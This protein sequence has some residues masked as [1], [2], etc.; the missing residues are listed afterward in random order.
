MKVDFYSDEG[1]QYWKRR[2]KEL[3]H[4]EEENSKKLARKARGAKAAKG[5]ETESP[6]KGRKSV[7]VVRSEEVPECTPHNQPEVRPDESVGSECDGAVRPLPQVRG[8]NRSPRK[9]NKGS[10]V[11]EVCQTGSTQDA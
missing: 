9:P 10:N 6:G 8:R 1:I 7:R 3:A 5:V 2:M 4:E 11:P